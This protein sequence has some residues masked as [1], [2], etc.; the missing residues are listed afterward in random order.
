MRGFRV[1]WVILSNS[2]RGQKTRPLHHSP[3]VCPA[4]Q[5]SSRVFP[6]F[7]CKVGHTQPH[8]FMP[9]CLSIYFIARFPFGRPF[10]IQ[11]ILNLILSQRRIIGQLS[12][13][14][15]NDFWEFSCFFA[16]VICMPI[17][18]PVT[19]PFEFFLMFTRAQSIDP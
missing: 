15:M 18:V 7:Q 9:W 3:T 6:I 8:L 16:H 12:D 10:T 11:R 17:T 2:R 19:L 14:S 4:L 1:R 5:A 13:L